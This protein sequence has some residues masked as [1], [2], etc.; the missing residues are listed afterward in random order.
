M[1]MPEGGVGSADHGKGHKV[2]M[3]GP[4]PM[5]NAMKC[6]LCWTRAPR[7]T[8]AGRTSLALAT[9]LPELCLSWKTRCSYSSVLACGGECIHLMV[10][11]TVLLHCPRPG[12]YVRGR[13]SLSW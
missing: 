8:R 9:L 7:L 11:S 12:S 13:P 1:H 10:L 3:C 5:M 2:L 6:V 4:P